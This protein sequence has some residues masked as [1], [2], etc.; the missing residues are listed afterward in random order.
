MPYGVIHDGQP[1]EITPGLAFTTSQ[2]LVGTEEEAAWS[3]SPIGSVIDFEVSHPG[4]ALEHYAPE[5]LARFRIQQFAEGAASPAGH[6]L[7]TRTL[8][9]ANG[10]ISVAVTYAPQPVPFEVS[11]MQ[12][13]LA[14]SAAGKLA[15][16]EAAVAAATATVQIYWKTAPTLHRDH[17][18]V[19]SL[20]AAVGLSGPEVDA[21]FVAAST[22]T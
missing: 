9:V 7:A 20:A 11:M 18:L 3:M 13:Q 17:P 10:A 12:A 19:A 16:V 4:N 6:V 2:L 21:L 14:L 8:V 5:D 15:A 22:I 1:V